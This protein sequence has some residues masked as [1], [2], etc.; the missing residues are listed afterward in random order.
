VNLSCNAN[1]NGGAYFNFAG[2]GQVMVTMNSNWN[3]VTSFDALDKAANAFV[4]TYMDSGGNV[5]KAIDAAN[6]VLQ[7]IP[8]ENKENVGDRIEATKVN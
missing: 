1:R 3:G 5:Q 7:R 2:N 8:G 6:K 4:K